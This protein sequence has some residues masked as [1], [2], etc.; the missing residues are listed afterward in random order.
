MAYFAGQKRQSRFYWAELGFM[1]L[2]LLGLQPSLLTNLIASAQ[3]RTNSNSDPRYLTQQ[4][5]AMRG[6][7]NFPSNQVASYLPAYT[8]VPP[9]PVFGWQ[10]QVSPQQTNA[11]QLLYSAPQQL[12]NAPQQ[13][14]STATQYSTTQ[15]YSTSQAYG[16]FQQPNHMPLTLY[17]QNSFSQPFLPTN[18]PTTNLLSQQF[19]SAPLS[20]AQQHDFQPARP[21]YSN[22]GQNSTNYLAQAVS[23]NNWSAS[24]PNT[25]A[26]NTNTYLPSTGYSQPKTYQNN[27]MNPYNVI[28]P[29]LTQNQLF[30]NGASSNYNG[31]TSAQNYLN[32]SNAGNSNSFQRYRAPSP[33]YR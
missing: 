32:Q 12:Y 27:A 11:Q 18:N 8:T 22:G 10:Q 5:Q 26:G 6:Y 29:R 30:E 14:Y 31:S 2:G 16:A 33:L 15:P 17:S 21:S 24:Q 1:A 13:P 9:T 28:A 3:S 23:S 7:E 25:Y 20:Y 19:N 4:G